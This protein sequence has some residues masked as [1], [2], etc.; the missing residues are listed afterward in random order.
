MYVGVHGILGK[1][2]RERQISCSVP[3][4]YS[5]W[6]RVSL[7]LELGRQPASPRDPAVS[8]PHSTGVTGIH[9]AAPCF[10]VGAKDLNSDPHAWTAS[11]L[12]H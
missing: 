6:D 1:A 10:L 9:L 12:T 5:L 4:S 11:A 8:A 2:R 7:N 3:L